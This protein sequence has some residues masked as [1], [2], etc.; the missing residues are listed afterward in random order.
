MNKGFT[1]IEV[2][3]YLALFSIIIGGGM[4]AVYGIIQSTDAGNNQIILQEEANFILRKIDWT[5]TGAISITT[6]ANPTPTTNLILTKNI[7]GSPTLFTFEINSNDV[8]CPV[9]YLCLKRGSAMSQ[10]NTNLFQLNSSSISIS[11]LSFKKTPTGNGIETNF[12]LTTEQNGR[13]V[14]QVFTTTKY[15]RN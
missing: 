12:T 6:P 14:S 9:K 15:L 4:V 3:I 1:L 13:N 5:L 2:V 11:N 8:I 10:L 7:S